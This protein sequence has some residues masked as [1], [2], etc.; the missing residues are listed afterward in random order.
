MAVC[1]F[2]NYI[3]YGQQQYKEDVD[4]NTMENG[5]YYQGGPGSGNANFN[6]KYPYGTKLTIKADNS[7]YRLF[8]IMTNQYSASKDNLYYRN[9]NPSGSTEKWSSWYKIL[10]EDK[11]GRV[12]IGTTSPKEKFEVI[13][14]PLTSLKTYPS[15]V[16][17]TTNSDGGWARGFRIRNE[18][19]NTAT[20]FGALNGDAYIA[21]G[22]DYTQSQS[23]YLNR[24]MTIK[25]EGNVGIGTDSPEAVLNINKSINN[26][27][28]T[29][30]KNTGGKS[31]GLL[32]QNG[33]GRSSNDNSSIILQCEDNDQNVRF[34]VQSNGKVGI[35]TST[36]DS[37]LTVA[38]KIHAQE[39][40]VTVSAGETPDY[41]FK[42]DYH[43]MSLEEIEK[44][45]QLHRHLPEVKSASQI[46]EEGL[47]LAEMNLLL[48]K[49]V[50]ELTLYTIEQEKEIS[51]LKNE[52]KEVQDL[53]NELNILKEMI[54]SIQKK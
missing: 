10:S 24:A 37:R 20:I 15:G 46:E 23:G 22:Y 30:I 28:T 31:Q 33:Y 44:Y 1:C 47:H 17:V 8:E 16:E 21:V 36:P 26:F 27:W 48:L 54:Q 32:I 18:R 9:Y 29:K 34:K 45:I 13:V 41:V 2:C 6:W 5:V 11:E 49:K 51:N 4:P 43:L 38:G 39:V 19:E 35:G 50:E 7:G 42:E 12:G 40:K 52:L 25:K 53:K 3:V 14:S